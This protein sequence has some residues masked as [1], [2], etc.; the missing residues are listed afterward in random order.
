MVRVEPSTD[1]EPAS[2]RV[3]CLLPGA[4]AMSEN[5]YLPPEILDLIADLMHDDPDALKKCCLVSKSWIPRTRR[6][7]FAEITFYTARDMKSWKRVFPGPS[8]SPARYTKSLVVSPHIVGTE[9]AEAGNWIK[10]FSRVVHLGVDDKA[11]Y[12]DKSE[13]SLL[14][15]HGFSPVVN[16]LRLQFMVIPSSRI[17]DLILSFPLLEDLSIVVHD[18][19]I[20]D[21]DDSNK[22]PAI[23]HSSNP[24]ILT[25]SLELCSNGGLEYITRRL[26]S[27]P[28]SIHFRELTSTLFE[29][30]DPSST[31]ALVEECSHTI[32]TLEISCYLRTSIRYYCPHRLL[33]SILVWSADTDLSKAERLK[34]AVFRAKSLCVG[35]IA[36]ALRT[37][38]PKH[39]DLQQISI[40]TYFVPTS[41]SPPSSILGKLMKQKFLDSGRSSTTF[42]SNSGNRTRFV[43]RSCATR[44]LRKGSKMR[45]S[46]CGVCYRKQ[47]GDG[48]ST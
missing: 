27:Q 8:I 44:C 41:T 43:R 33:T 46:S 14:F 42:S 40:H 4:T 22:P 36:T 31:T 17:F 37:I 23:V 11:T 29:V 26:L 25:G 15:F 45:T 6:H 20:D 12:V 28:G 19:S 24:P 32:E 30:G 35:W 34:G 9:G 13:V 3:R 5:A 48:S 38:T 10:G 39:Q 18:K 21:G 1:P 16:S 47:L 2:K 7:L